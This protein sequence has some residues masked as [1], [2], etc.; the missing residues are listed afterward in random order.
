MDIISDFFEWDSA[1]EAANIKKH[2]IDFDTA[3]LVFEDYFRIEKYDEAH[4]GEEDRY[5]T[6]G[7]VHDVLFVVYTERGTRTR[8]ISARLADK[9]ERR[10]YNAS[11]KKAR[12]RGETDAGTNRHD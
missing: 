5:N 11:Y 10:K 12:P 9:A 6:I 3:S 2:G 1:K 7:M 8:I 4:S